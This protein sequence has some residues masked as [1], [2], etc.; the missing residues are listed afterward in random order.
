[1]DQFQVEFMAKVLLML[2]K[3]GSPVTAYDSRLLIVEGSHYSQ[4]RI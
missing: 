1:M 3:A 4:Y 2:H